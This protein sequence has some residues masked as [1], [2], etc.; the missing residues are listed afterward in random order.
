MSVEK[1]Q[2]DAIKNGAVLV[3]IPMIHHTSPDVRYNAVG[4]LSNVAET[5]RSQMESQTMIPVLMDLLRRSEE[6]IKTKAHAAQCLACIAENSTARRNIGIDIPALRGLLRSND[7]KLQVGYTTTCRTIYLL[8][9]S[10]SRHARPDACHSLAWTIVFDAKSAP[11][12]QSY[13]LFCS[14]ITCKRRLVQIVIITTL[15][16]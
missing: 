7:W 9:I 14:P 8:L 4:A 5:G 13:G 1:G 12:Y 11:L 3:L 16:V 6:P 15:L 10:F 2:L